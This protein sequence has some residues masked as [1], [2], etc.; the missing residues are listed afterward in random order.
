MNISRGKIRRSGDKRTSE[1]TGSSE[2]SAAARPLAPIAP[3][4]PLAP[5]APIDSALLGIRRGR[6]LRREVLA[7][8]NES[9]E[10]L[11]DARQ[12]AA[13]L[14]AEA[15]DAAAE[16]RAIAEREGREAG[17]AQLSTKLIELSQRDARSDERQLDRTIELARVLAERLLGDELRLHPDRVNALARVALT[18]LGAARQITI[19]C[20]PS[21]APQLER[22]LESLL[23]AEQ[24]IDVRQDDT[25][26]RGSLRLETELGVLDGELGPR[27][28]R[29]V[30]ELRR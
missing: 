27:L 25:R 13:S 5:L 28:D 16:H 22:A 4:A 11:A 7:A 17:A 2:G 15:R 19:A 9:S 24:S 6:I 14:L 10:T 26:G 8:R 18:E 3:I 21:D 12:R 20:H 23:V 29:L 30:Q 1:A